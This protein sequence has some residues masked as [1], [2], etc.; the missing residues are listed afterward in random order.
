MAKV[1]ELI[2]VGASE[3]IPEEYETSVEIFSRV[4]GAYLVPVQEIEEY[5]DQVRAE[6]YSMWRSVSGGRSSLKSLDHMHLQDI[7]LITVR[8]YEGSPAAGKTLSEIELR[9]KY[10]VNLVAVRR[11]GE[12]LSNPGGETQLKARDDLILLGSSADVHNVSRQL[13]KSV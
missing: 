6:G 8:V 12:V 7:D 3:V 5:V 2:A 11:G 9:N 13:L 1:D 4:L 10:H